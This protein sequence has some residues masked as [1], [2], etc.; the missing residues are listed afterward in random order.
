[1][2]IPFALAYAGIVGVEPIVGLHTVPL[3]LA[4]V[5]LVE[6]ISRPPAAVLSR[7]PDGTWRDPEVVV[8]AKPVEGLVVWRQEARSSS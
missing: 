5:L 2:L 6:H 8:A 1:V 3:G 7:A 4:L